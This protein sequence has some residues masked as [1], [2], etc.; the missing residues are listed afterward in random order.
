MNIRE[1]RMG[2][3]FAGAVLLA[4]PVAD[5]LLGL[6]PLGIEHFAVAV[7]GLWMAGFAAVGRL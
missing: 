4:L 6:R 7:F 1:A 2:A 5:A 3:A